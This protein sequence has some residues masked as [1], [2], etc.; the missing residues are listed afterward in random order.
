MNS[1][2][3]ESDR[4]DSV[5]APDAA[6]T[7][8]ATPKKV[9]IIGLDGATM[10]VLGPLM[11]EGRLPHLSTVAEGGASG[12]L[13][14][15]TPPIT[16]AAW[17]TFLT[18]KQPG[19]HG[20][21]DFERY[22]P[23]TNRLQFN[24]T[25]CLDHV[26]NIWQIAG[27][28]GL[29]VGSVN[30]PMTYPPIKVNGFLVSGFETPGPDSDFVFPLSIKQ[31]ILKRWPD[32]TL[33]SKWK[34]KIFGGDKLFEQNI[35]YASRSF[36]QGA[37]MTTYLGEKFGWDVLM[38]VFKL[39]DN[40]QHKT[41]KYIDPR[42]SDRNPRRRDMVKDGFEQADR[43]VGT[44]LDYAKQNQASVVIVSDH[45]H[46]SLEG[47]V[48]PNLLL[49]QWEY[50]H[51]ASGGSR[52]AT[53][54]RHL[55][56]R[57]L[58]KNKRFARAG[59]IGHD[60]AVDFSRTRACVMHAGMAGF[61]YLNL[62][63]RQPTG[64]VPESAYESL[65]D[66]IRER[67]LGPECRAV[68][69]QGRTIQLF[70]EVHKPEELYDCSR[71]DQPWLPDLMLIPYDSLAVVRK[72]RGSSP[73]R[74]LP[75]RRI[76][77]T[78]RSDGIIMACGPDVARRNDLRAHIVDC[79]PTIL[80]MLGLSIP[81]DMQGRVITEMFKTPPQIKTTAGSGECQPQ[82]AQEVYSEADLREV[83]NRLADLGYL[84]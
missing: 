54:G 40:L 50:L 74:W 81:A 31:E 3:Q 75:F 41:W 71:D 6:S 82:F 67:L 63:G 51:L 65:R 68:D 80:A 77:G 33:R 56:D 44:L 28:A 1:S 70:S 34:R 58:G 29:K 53:R 79:A 20:I 23:S 83:T 43:A 12:I 45:G 84:E 22:D 57:A 26:R 39:V 10:D 15:T 62:Q 52:G 24:S 69:P 30:V 49:K 27:D 76:E 11:R 42:W 60:L 37:E 73:I 36:H 14:S 9:L 47:K 61:L 78:H 55:L 17:T 38:V 8:T 7:G 72:I 2:S 25:R 35:A 66:E 16:P 21:I 32:P 5:E 64:I 18:G 59:D 4:E 13:R 46:G 19:A 48:Q